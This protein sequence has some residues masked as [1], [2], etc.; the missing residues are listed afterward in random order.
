[1]FFNCSH[2][3]CDK[4]FNCKK[5]LKEHERTHNQDRPFKWFVFYNKNHIYYQNSY[6]FKSDISKS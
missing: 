2:D 4:V 6:S 3:G 1:M 5:A